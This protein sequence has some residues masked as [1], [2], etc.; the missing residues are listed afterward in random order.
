MRQALCCNGRQLFLRCHH[1]ERSDEITRECCNR[2]TAG[3]EVE[4]LGAVV[5]R[6]PAIDHAGSDPGLRAVANTR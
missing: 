2:R 3:R 5:G 4:D 1:A 6:I